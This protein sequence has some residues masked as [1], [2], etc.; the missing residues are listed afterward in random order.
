MRHFLLAAAYSACIAV[1]FACLL[2]EDFRSV[3]RLFLTVFSV[4]TGG[5]FV[6]GWV[7]YLLSG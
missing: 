5:V 6:L 4:M 1:F 7:M 2:R 3:R